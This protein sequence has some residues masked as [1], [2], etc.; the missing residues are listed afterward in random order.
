MVDI[1]IPHDWRPRDYQLP[2]WR[3]FERGGKRAC[4]IWHRRAG[5]DDVLLHLTAVQAMQRPGN[6]WHLLP[7][8][9][10]ARKAIWE[11][12]NP[13]TGKRRIDE[14]FPHVLR[15]AT[16]NQ[17]M[18]ITFVNGSTWHVLGS[19]SYNALVGSPPVGLVY[20]EWALSD[21]QSWAYLR[22]ILAEN[23][24][25][26]AFVST[27]RGPN[28]C[29]KT[30][31]TAAQD[32]DWFAEI[33][34]AEQTCVFSEDA[35]KQE[36]QAYIREF[37]PDL[38]SALYEQEY[39]C[40]F[41]AAVLGAY[42]GGEMTAMR[43]E[44]RITDV[45][46][47]PSYH[48]ET[49]WDLGIRDAMV[50]LFVQRIGAHVR[51]IDALS[52]TGEGLPYYAKQVLEKRYAYSRHVFPHDLRVRELGNGRT[53]WEIVQ[54][55]LGGGVEIAPNIPLVDGIDATRRLLPM[56]YVDQRKCS[57]LIE[58]LTLY[59]TDW[60]ASRAVLGAKPIHDWTSH[61]ADALR[62][63]AI[64]GGDDWV[65]LSQ[66]ARPRAWPKPRNNRIEW[67]QPLPYRMAR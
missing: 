9:V 57:T 41:E 5:K 12:V 38:G 61:W 19:D 25:W 46:Y 1:T 24:G 18:S 17:E 53:R 67:N 34:T 36:R 4:A 44:G 51:V 62:M 64:H 48:V 52:G 22:P 60:D 39:M 6:Y 21:P 26:A 58:A 40:S 63:G 20:S 54:E 30:F 8:Q 3:Y 16:R 32:P 10:Q 65:D 23:G 14:A 11:A 37:G 43:E 33:L 29:K 35:L 56:L 66:A 50:I 28:H 42:Y 45:P 2:L 47:D 7:L 55:L 15:D 59:R 49:W 27:P 13:H 31:D